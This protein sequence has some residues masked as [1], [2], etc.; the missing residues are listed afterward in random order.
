[1]YKIFIFTALRGLCFIA[2][3]A[4]YYSADLS[5]LRQHCDGEKMKIHIRRKVVTS[6]PSCH[7]NAAREKTI[8][9]M[10]L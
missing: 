5:P 9:E 6:C 3:F 10:I 8:L 1:M 4:Q 2:L 7:A